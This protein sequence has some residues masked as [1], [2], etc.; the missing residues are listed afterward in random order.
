MD[1]YHLIAMDLTG[2]GDSDY[3]YE[4][5]ADTY[6][7]EIFALIKHANLNQDTIIVGHSFS[8]CMA[9]K[10]VAQTCVGVSGLVLVD[11][12]IHH[13]DEPIPDYPPLGGTRAKVYPTREAGE[14]RFRL[15]PPQPSAKD[16]LL[17]YIA[18]QSLLPVEG[19]YAWKFDEDLPTSLTGTDAFPEDY[20]N[21]AVP[22]AL[23]YGQNSLSYSARTHEYMKSLVPNVISEIMIED[24]QHHV[25][26]DQP[27][28]FT[29]ALR[30]VLREI[31][32]AS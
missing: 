26:L 20:Q 18:R 27:L 12:G 24:A 17:K 23:M 5:S 30:N 32:A 13:P 8:G 14:S 4:Y 11:S 6:I 16:Y 15:F 2:M 28:A 19:G 21:L 9:T 31:L 10:A 7:E 3:R 22:V 29:D 1:Q 25:F